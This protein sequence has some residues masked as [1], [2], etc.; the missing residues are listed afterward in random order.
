MAS[1]R[2]LSSRECPPSSEKLVLDNVLVW[3]F[4]QSCSVVSRESPVSDAVVP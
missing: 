1:V 3:G 4:Q 2:L